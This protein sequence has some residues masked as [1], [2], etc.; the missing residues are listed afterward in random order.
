MRRLEKIVFVY[1]DYNENIED[2]Y[3]LY[4]LY[5]YIDI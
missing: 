5:T 1:K 3:L 2:I 4:I